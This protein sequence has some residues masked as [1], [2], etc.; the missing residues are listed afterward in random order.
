MIVFNIYHKIS[1]LPTLRVYD[2]FKVFCF[3]DND[4]IRQIIKNVS[5]F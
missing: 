4:L 5:C 1:L 2:S 3:R